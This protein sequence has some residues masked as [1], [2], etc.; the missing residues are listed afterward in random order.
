[1]AKYDVV[2]VGAGNSGLSAALELIK[3]NKKVLLIEQHNLPGG[4]ATSFVRGRFEFDPSL[5]ELCG[6]GSAKEPGGVRRLMNE[7]GVKIDW[8]PIKDCF[9]VISLYSDGTPMDVTMPV[10]VDNFIKAMEYYVPGSF[11]SMKR[12]FELF[13]EV[14]NG[15]EY[16]TGSVKSPETKVLQ[17]EYGNFLRTGGYS[18]NKVFKAVGLPQKARDILSAYWS[19]LGVP[20]DRLNFIHFA[21]MVLSYVKEGPYIPKN[22]SHEISVAM[23]ER[24]RD[25][26]GEIWMNCRAEEFIFNENR[27][28]GVRTTNGIVECD[29]VLANINPDIVYSKMVPPEL[30]PAKEKK[31]SSARNHNYSGRMFTCYFGLDCSAERLGISDY[32]TFFYGTSDSSKEYRNI[33]NGFATDD[34]FIFLCYNIANPAFS[35]DGTCVVSLTTF[36]SAD[37]WNGLDSSD[38]GWQKSRVAS[39]LVRELREIT[40]I[41]I[42]PHIEEMETAS[43]LTFARYLNTPEGCVYGYEVADWDSMMA[44]MMMLSEEQS[45]KGLRL[46]GAAGAYGVGYNMT[47][48][49]GQLEAMLT[50][51]DMARDRMSNEETTQENPQDSGLNNE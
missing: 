36:T 14:Q 29:Y 44:R 46:I 23:I 1:M 50:L 5:H 27:L 15:V 31:L 37:D 49:T 35:P 11:S 6:V 39:E 17:E 25:L 24:F 16:L 48:A 9:R 10:G 32:S 30:V 40:G 43:P 26:G 20:L 42:A 13:E 7:Y 8:I 51:A 12:L 3:T 28:C 19:Y 18:V 22:T 45:I 2:V 4:C 38:Y 41:D 21:E 47:Y 33:Q 34:F